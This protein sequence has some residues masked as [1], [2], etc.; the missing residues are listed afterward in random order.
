MHCDTV[1]EL[2]RL[3]AWLL[4]ERSKNL[5]MPC[6]STLGQHHT[7]ACVT[8]TDLS[9]RYIFLHSF[10]SKSDQI[11]YTT[12]ELWE[13]WPDYL[14]TC[15]HCC[16]VAQMPICLE[17][18]LFTDALTHSCAH[19]LYYGLSSKLVWGLCCSLLALQLYRHAKSK[20]LPCSLAT[21]AC[22]CL[23]AVRLCHRRGE[24]Q[25]AWLFR[26]Q[27]GQLP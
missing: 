26:L 21:H 10:C 2:S 5:C 15:R 7:H 11:W 19:V 22:M 4:M 20:W 17:P 16:P 9:Q 23:A 27:Q 12:A 24:S 3:E 18:A 14:E 13:V 8:A 25:S 6:C 1:T